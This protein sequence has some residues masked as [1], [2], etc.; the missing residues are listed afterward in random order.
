MKNLFH[1]YLRQRWKKK[2]LI[3]VVNNDDIDIN[4]YRNLAKKY[5]R[6]S[7]YRL[8]EIKSLG[9]CLNLGVSKSKYGIVAKFDD[10][11]YY[12]PDYLKDCMRAFKKSHADIIGRRAHYFWLKQLKTLILRFPKA[13]NKFVPVVPGATLVFKKKVFKNV[14]FSNRSVGEDTKFCKDSRVKGFKIFSGSKNHFVAIRRKNSADHTWMISYKKLLKSGIRL[15]R[16]RNY[17]KYVARNGP[18]R[19]QRERTK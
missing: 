4:I 7:V 15:P 2:E 19:I 13:E 6:I 9:N 16:V 11:D 17:K 3:I 18:R 12:A 14:R 10:D 5:K 1:N 8:P